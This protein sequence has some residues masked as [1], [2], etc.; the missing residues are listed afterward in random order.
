LQRTASALNSEFEQLPLRAASQLTEIDRD[1]AALSQET[2]DAKSRDAFALTA[3]IDGTVTAINAEPGQTV[4]SQALAIIVPS[5]VPMVAHL[6]A[7]SKAVGFV[8]VGQSVRLRYQPYPFQRFGTQH[9]TVVEVSTSPLSPDDIALLP[10]QPTRESLYRVV[11]RLDKSTIQAQGLEVA[12]LPGTAPEADIEQAE[13]R[14]IDWVLSPLK[15]AAT[16]L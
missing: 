12:L 3:P 1:I 8:Q 5:H 11:V 7:P 10:G 14:L 6:Y 4:T 16:R 13:Q 15:S 9:G 2:A